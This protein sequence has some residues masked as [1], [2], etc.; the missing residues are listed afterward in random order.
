M[1]EAAIHVVV[2]HEHDVVCEALSGLLQ[3]DPDIKVTGCAADAGEALAL[4]GRV[5]ADVVLVHLGLPHRSAIGLC[6]DI[7]ARHPH[8]QVLVL[9]AFED[10]DLLDRALQAGAADYVLKGVRGLNLPARVRDVA[11][12]QEIEVDRSGREFVSAGNEPISP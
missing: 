12:R 4:L 7:R 2:V 11:D 3:V 10:D 9:T 5:G 8:T 1:P 6:G